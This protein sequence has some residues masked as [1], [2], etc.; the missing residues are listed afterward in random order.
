MAALVQGWTRRSVQVDEV[1]DKDGELTGY[2]PKDNLTILKYW[3]KMQRKAFPYLSPA[4]KYLVPCP[5]TNTAC[6]SSFSTSSNIVGDRGGQMAD[7][8]VR[9]RTTLKYDKL[10][11]YEANTAP[12]LKR[13]IKQAEDAARKAG[14]RE[15]ADVEADRGD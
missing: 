13:M 6:E 10:R 15:V 7:S 14:E 9:G 5:A 11:V 2:K 1:R 12:A 4:L 8:T 3:D